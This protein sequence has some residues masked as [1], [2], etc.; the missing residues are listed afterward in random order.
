MG[1]EVIMDGKS[2]GIHPDLTNTLHNLGRGYVPGMKSTELQFV[3]RQGESDTANAA[4]NEWIDYWSSLGLGGLGIAS[5]GY[6]AWQGGKKGLELLQ[7]R[8][9][10]KV[11]TDASRIPELVGDLKAQMERARKA[12]ELLNSGKKGIDRTAVGVTKAEA[13]ALSARMRQEVAKLQKG[14]SPV[15]LQKAKAVME[16]A[17]K[18]RAGIKS[19]L[20]L[21][22]AA[23]AFGASAYAGSKER[24]AIEQQA[25][26]RAALEQ[27]AAQT[28][29]APYAA[30]ALEQ[31]A[32]QTNS[33]PYA[34]SAPSR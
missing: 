2:Y 12:E 1:T 7:E 21:G 22:G 32:A 28:N 23:L 30:S 16:T 14:I 27:L 25:N 3:Q 5:L 34:A 6:G 29:S 4:R 19:L 9:A 17:G 8:G 31:L 11:L 20:G 26:I 13:D 24:Q 10:N 33:A 15:K 18:S